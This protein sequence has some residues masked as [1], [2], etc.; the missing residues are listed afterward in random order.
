MPSV[1]HVSIVSVFADR[2]AESPGAVAVVCGDVSLTYGELDARAGR[3]ARV[4]VGRGVGVESRVGLLLERS[5]DVVVAMLAVVRAGGVYVP[6]HGSY[7]EERVRE[8][9]GR[10]GAVV[11]VTDRGLGEVGGVSAVGVDAGPVG[12]AVLPV[13]V[14]AGSLAYV[15]FTSGSTGVPKG[16][17][18]THGDVVALA[19]DSRW[20]ASGAHGRVLFHSPHSFDAAT[21]EVWVPLLNGGTADVAEAELSVS[22]VRAAVARGVSGLF[23]TKALFDVLAEEDPGCFAGLGEVWTG[24]EAA[25]GAAMARV[26]EACPETEL[27]HAYG[28]T[29]STTFAVCGPVGGVDTEGTT[30]PLGGPMDN[31]SAYVLDD[32]LRP[33]GVGVSGE[34]YLGGAGLARGYDGRAGLTAER[35]VAD[36]FGSGERLYRT[37]DV[38]RWRSDG[39]LDFLGR[40]DGQV[41]VRG[42][43]I[44]LGE[45][46]SVLSR[47]AA[48]GRVSVIVRED[49]PGA[50]RLVAYLV[51][52]SG[53]LDVPLVREHAAGLLPEYMVPS[54]FVV[55]DE[56][57]LT[58]NGKVD[59]R[60]L[61][62]PDAEVAADYVAP[63]TDVERLLCQVWAEVLGAERVGVHD[64]FF[65]RG[66][67]SI[68]GLK[69]V[70]RVQ[71]ALG[72]ELSTRTVFDHPTVSAMA[73]AVARAQTPGHVHAP[74]PATSIAPV[75]RDRE[76]PLSYGQERLW[77][78]DDF[79]PG[80]VEYNTGLALRLTGDLDLAALRAALD[81][82]TAR[83]E[84]LRTTFGGGVQTVHPTLTVPL[85]A[86]DLSTENDADRPHA[87]DKVLRTE[88]S[89]PFDLVAGPLFRVLTVRLGAEEHVLVL[90]MHHIVT[91]GWSMGVVTR[92]LGTLYAAA[93]RGEDADLEELSVQYPDFAVW[94]READDAL[95]QQLGY[96][97]Q[98]LDGLEPLELPTDRP[99]PAVRTSA[100]ALHTF[101]V[102]GELVRR[103]ARSGQ[104]RGASMFMV[105]TAV[106]QLLLS[107]YSGQRDVAVGTVVSGR[108]RADLE[109][110]VGFFVN[111]LVLRARIDQDRHSF[112]DLLDHVRTT[113][114]DA[115]AHQEVPFDRV[116]DALA[117]ERDPS[118]TPLVQA[119]I[120]LQNSVDMAGDFAGLT[121][122]REPV[123][124]ESSRFDLTL[125]FWESPSG[126]T[127]ELE[128][129]TDLFDVG[130]VERLCGHWLVL[131]ERVVAEPLVPLV[132]VGMLGAGELERLL[133]EWAGPGVGV[134]ERSV[135]EL[136]QAR[137]DAAPGA[138]AVLGEGGVS[139]T[140]GELGGRVDRLAGYLASLGVGV[141]SRVGVSLPRSV[142]LVVAVLAVLRAGGAYVPLDPEYP[143]DRL[144]FMKAD[145]GVRVVVDEAMVAGPLLGGAGA[146]VALPV[147]D[148]VSL[149]SAAYVIYTSGSTGRP[150]G[151]VVPHGAMAGL[152]RWAVSLG[153]ERFSR[154][155]F[156]TS[157]NFDVSV[158]ELFGTL[159]A[160]GTVEVVRDVLALTERDS[161]SGSLV[162]AVPSAFAGV[163]GQERDVSA[164]LVVL[165]GEAFPAGLL[166]Q[167]RQAMPGAV[168]ANI[169][170]PTEA[171]VYA[172]GWFS[173]TDPASDGP[174]VPIGRPVAG[175]ATYVLDGGLSP[176]PVGVWG[177]LYLGGGLARGYHGRSGLTSER[178]VA[179]PFRSG[180]RLYRTGD[181]VRWR[182]DG[183]LEYAGR[184]DDQVK[185]RGFRIELGEI[186]S[187]LTS[188]ASV[189]QSV[190]VARED[191]P[192][193]KRLAA[194]LVADGDVGLDVDAVREHVASALPEYMVPAAFVVLDALPLNANGK[195]DRRS[196][197]APEF[198]AAESA[199][200]APRT[201][202]ERIL[203]GVWAEVLGLSRVGIEDNFFD[204]GGDSIISLQ[205][206]SRARRA[207]LALSSRD[208][209][210]H[211][212]I[213]TL[214]TK[215]GQV[216]TG[217]ALLAE[218]GLVTGAVGTTPV[219]EWFFDTHPVA[220]EHF[221]MGAGFT[222]SPGTDLDA[223]RAAVGA[224]LSQHDALRS[225]FTRT[226]DGT[227]TGHITPAVD[228]DAV[229]TVHHS[230]TEWHS[231]VAAAHAGLDLECGPLFRVLVGVTGPEASI[232]V[233]LAAHHLVVDGVSWRILLE[234][235]ESAYERIVAG[236]QP[237][238][239]PKGTSVRQWATRLAEHTAAG[240]FDAQLP[241]WLATTDGVTTRLPVD[242]PGGDNTVQ[243]ERSVSVR[244]SAEETRALLQ[245]V[246]A[247][248]RTRPNDVLLSALVRAAG[249]WAGGSR[250]AVD[251]EA[252]GR[253]EIFADTDLTRTVGWFT[254]IHPVVLDV[255]GDEGVADWRGT[256]RA[257]KERLRAVPDQGVGYG[258]LRYL[259]SPEGDLSA[260]PSA[261]GLRAAP[262]PE[263]AFNYL[264]QFGGADD[265]S[266]W[267]RSLVLNPGGEHHPA[268]LRSHVLEVVGAVQDGVL[269]F[270]W[271]YSA[272]L[273]DRATVWSLAERFTAELRS[274][275][276][277]CAE[278]DS[279][280]CSPSDFPLVRLTQAEIDL[281]ADDGRDIEDIYPLT[282]LQSGMLFHSLNA[283]GSAA[284]LEQFTFVMDGVADLDALARAWQRVV[285]ASD[286]LRVS[287][288]WEGLS[289]PVQIVHRRAEIPV[290]RVD[291]TGRPEA[292]RPELLAVLVAEDR[293]A[294]GLDPGSAPLTRVTLA[295][296][297]G[298]RVQV[299]WS[300]HHMLLD[301]WSSAAVLSDVAAEYA[302]EC[303]SLVSEAGPRPADRPARGAFREHL[304]WLADCD[305][306][307]GRAFWRDRLAGFEEPSALPFDRA[308][309]S[310]HRARSTD[311]VTLRLPAATAHAVVDFARRSRVTVGTMVHGAWALTLSQYAGSSDVVFGSTVSGRP[312]DQPGAESTVGLFINTLPVRIDTTPAEPVARWLR[313]IGDE[314]AEARQ[315]EYVA[316]HEISTDVPSGAALFDSLVVVE[317]Y[318]VDPDAAARHGIVLSGLDAVEST[319][320]PLT[321]TARA[322]AGTGEQFV[323]TFG[324]DPELFDADTVR[325]LAE[326]CARAL[327]ELAEDGERIVGTLTLLGGD[328][329]ARVLGEWSG[330][331]D[332]EAIPIVRPASVT[333]AFRERVAASPDAA[334][335]KC[336][337]T[338]LS[339][340]QLGRRADR[341]A[342]ALLK[343]GVGAGSRVGLLLERSSEV[344]VAMLAVLKAGGAYVPLHA[345]HPAR[346]MREV[347]ERS[348]AELLLIDGTVRAPEGVAVLDMADVEA[349]AG[350]AAEAASAPASVSVPSQAP[351]YV[352][353]TSG[354]TG[355]PK[356]VVVTHGGVVA[357]AADRRFGSETHRQVLFHSP[358]SFDAATYEVWGP[359]LN[360]GCVVVAD[361]ELTAQAVRRAAAHGVTAVFVTTALFGALADEDPGCF[362]GLRE[363]WT[364]GEAASAPAMA[365]MRAHCPDTELMHVYGPTETTTFAL[366]GPVAA[367]DT[368]GGPVPLGGP[369]DST[370]AYVLD[371]A[372]RPVGVG[373][374]GELYLG[375]SGLARGY[376][377]RAA[378]TAERFVADP[379]AAGARLYR[380]GDIV[381]RRDDGRVEFLGRND[382]QV[383]IRGF[384]IELGEIEALL[385][386]GQDIAAVAVVA[387]EDRPGTKRLVAYL[388]PAGGAVLDITS[389]REQLTATLPAYMVPSAFVELEALPLTV[390]G[391]VDRRA[392][393]APGHGSDDEEPYVA[394]RPG[395]EEL[396][397]GIWGEVLGT[398]QVGA[399]DDFFALGG[400]SIA[401][402]KVVSRVRAALGS[403]LSPRALFDHPTVA[404]LAAAA[405][406]GEDESV[407]ADPAGI[408]IAPAPRDGRPLP[409]SYAQE[410][411][412]FLDEFTP[413]G[414]E[415]NVVTTLRLTGT[416]DLSALQAAVSGLVARHEALRTTFDSADG[417]GVQKVHPALDVTVR[418]A[419]AH[420]E[421]E[422]DGLLRAEAAEPFDLRTGPLLRVLLVPE[423]TPA[424]S[425]SS[426]YLLMLTLHHIT[427]DGWSMGVITRELSELYAAALRGGGAELPTLPVQYPDY[428]VWQRERLTGDALDTHL[429]Y[430]REHLRE[431][432]VLELPTDRPRPAVRSGRGALH[433]FRVPEELTA[434][435]TEAAGRR[436][437]TL[438]M[439]LTAVTQLL[440]ARYSGQD[441]LAVATAVSGRERTELE[442]LVG[443]FVNTLILR[444]RIE[445]TADFAAL[446]AQ[447]RETTLA[448]FAHQ[449]VPF[450][451]LVEELD[452]ERDPSRTPLV[453]AAVTL[454]NAPRETFALPGLRVEETLPPVETAQFD[455]NIEFEPAPGRGLFAVVSYG[456]DLFDAG[457]VGRMAGHW[458][459]LAGALVAGGSG[460]VLGEVSMLGVV[461]REWV[462]GAGR[463]VVRGLSGGSVVEGFA[464]RVAE[465]PG[466]V[467]V[468][469]GDVLLTY[470]ELEAR[471][472]R[473]ARVL[474]ECGVGV[475]SRVGLLLERSVDVVVAMLAVVR[476]GGVYV[477]LHG[478]YP[479][480]RVREVLGRSGAVVVVTDRGLGE[481]GGVS[482]V[483]V[484]AG[485]VGD[486]ALPVRVAAGSLAYV[487]FTSGSTGVPK[488]VAVTH[489]DV[490]ALAADSR[491]SSGAH[492]RVLFHSPHSFD[493]A[494]YE[495]WVP[496]LNGGT[497]DVAE[498]DL[499]VSVVRAAVARGV[500]GVFLTKALFD[501]LAEEDPACFAGLGEVWT[502]GE[503]ASGAAMARVLEACPEIELVHV[504]GPTE[505]TT[506]AVCGP[507]EAEDVSA[508]AVP[509]GGPMDNTSAY[510]LD[511]SLQPT[512]IGVPGELY[513]GGA[514]LARG[515]DGRAGLTAER[516]VADP[517][518]SGGRLYRTG[519]VVRWQSDG[520]LDFL[521]R[522]DGQVKV[523]GFRIELGEIESVL[524]R[525]PAV[526][527]VSVIVREDRPG[528]KRLVAYLVP[529]SGELDVPLVREHAA[530]LLPEYMVPSAFVVL[531]ALPLTTNGKVDQR[532]LPAPDLAMEGEYVAPR[533]EAERVLCEVWADVL[534]RERVGVHDNF[535]SLGGD[536]ISS[537]QVVSRARRA[538]LDLTSR[539]VFLRQNIADLAAS[540]VTIE[541]RN[542]V[543]APQE[544]VSG[545]V[546]PTPIREW[547]FAHHPAAPHHFAMS[548]AFEL[549]VGTDPA[550][551]RSAVAA[552]LAQ[553]D[554]LRSTF[555]RTE[556][557]AHTSGWAGCIAP[558]TDVDAVFTVHDL[559]SAADAEKAWR[560]QVL[561]AQSGMDLSSGPLFRV[562]VGD[563]GPERPGWLF[564]AAH[565]LL[566][567]G[568]SWRILLEDLTRA[569]AQAAAGR[570]VR[571]GEKSASVQQWSRRLAGHVAAGGFDDQVG[572]W[573][574]VTDAG[575]TELPV[576]L[577]GGGN[578]MAAQATVDV[579][580]DTEE[581]AALLHRV[582]D[583]YR[584][585][586]DDVLLAALARTLR[587]W[588]G[589]ERTA[590]AVEGH[591]RE[592]LFGDLDLTRTVGWFTSI[593]PVALALPDSDDQASALMSVKEQLRAVPD[594]GLGYGALRHLAADSASGRALADAAEP[595][596]SFNYHGRFEGSADTTG[597]LRATLPAFGQDHHPAEE[598]AHLIDVIGV[599]AGGRL[600]FTWTYSTELH[601][602]A[603]IERLAKDFASE[604]SGFVRHCAQPDA[605]GR[606]PSDFPLA[607]LDQGTVDA[608]VG[609]GQA[610]RESAVEDIYPLTPMQSGM[611]LHTLT[612]PGV[613]LDQVSFLLEGAGDPG[614]L[615][616][617]WQ[618]LVDATPALRTQ[619]VWDGV[620][621]PLQVVRRHAAVDIRQLDW[622]DANP[623]EQAVLL[624]EL[625]D[626]EHAAGIDLTVAP[627]MRLV[628]IRAREGAVRVVWTFHHVV[629]D[630]WSTTQ[631][632]ED[633]FAQYR[634]V[635]SGAGGAAPLATRPPFR[636]YVEWLGRQD[637][638]AAR[639]Y[640]RGALAGFRSPTPLPVDRRPAPGHRSHA[641]ER[642]RIELSTED[643]GALTEMAGRHRLTLNSVVQGAWA[644]LLSRYSGESDVCFGATVSGRPADLP[645]MESTV[646][647]FLNTLP[648]RTRIPE[649]ESLLD[650]LG[651]LQTEQA[652]ARSFE[653][654]ALREVR[655][656]A[657]L[658]RGTE[659]FESIVVFENYPGNEEAAAAHGLRVTDVHAVD[660]AGYPLDL[661]AYADRDKLA[662]VLAYDPALFHHDRVAHM[663]EHLAVLLRGMPG[664]AHRPPADLPLLSDRG[665]D[666]LLGGQG[667]GDG[668]GWSG[669]RI[670]YED[671]S[672][673]HELIAAQA[674]RTPDAE[675]VVFG[676]STLTYAELD[677]RA[678]RLAQHLVTRGVGPETVTAICLER[679]PDMVVALLG[680]LKAGGAY[681]PLDPAHPAER[682]AYVLTDSAARLVI[683]QRSLADRLPAGPAPLLPL[684]ERWDLI[685]RLPDR[686]PESGV[687]PRDLAYVIYT[688]G[689]T[690][691]PKG[692]M[693]EHRSISHGAASWNAAY[694]FTGRGE[695]E[696][697][698]VGVP[699]ASEPEAGGAASD[700]PVS[701]GPVRQ[702]N[703]ASMSFDVFVSDLVHSLCHGGALVIAPPEAIADPAQL[704]TLI[705]TAR[706]T[707]LDTVPALATALADEAARYGKGL[708]LLRVLA[709]GADL[710]RTDDCR[711][712]L[713]Q[714]AEGTTVLNTYGVTEA[715]VESSLYPAVRGTLPDTAG[716]PIGRPNPGI[717]MYL[718]D[719]AL[720]PVP[721][722]VTGDLYLGGPSVARGYLNRPELTAL[723]FV[724][725]PFGTDPAER[726]Y[727]TGDRARYLPGGDIEFAGRADEQLK[728]RG[729]RIEPGEIE[730]ALR[731]HPSV[732]RAVVAARQ[733]GGGAAR[734]VG[735][736]VV[737]DGHTFAPGELRAHLKRLLPGYMVPSVFMELAS[738]P[739]NANGKVDR[740]ALPAP[741]AAA[742]ADTAYIAPRT[743][744]EEV[745]ADIWQEVLGVERIGAEDDFFELGGNSI[746]IL[747]INSR[748]RAAFGVGFSVRAFYD[749][750]TVA[751]LAVAV[752]ERILQELEDSM[753]R[754]QP[755][756][757]EH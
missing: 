193:V 372:L 220:P 745:L 526:G 171:T 366:C 106:T 108:E 642:V 42:F 581:T 284:Y 24:G 716:V 26:L 278:P 185:V 676:A 486:A 252:H 551:L 520:R 397:A 399:H 75:P 456:T 522:N 270:T 261:P 461:E 447:V 632:F 474:V 274:L 260:S 735:Y 376:D 45:I 529:S 34:L 52:S 648:V 342:H 23:L 540:A 147:P 98:Q 623:D 225:T 244:L 608:L 332:H 706:V 71:K 451:R 134:G 319:N 400:D 552:L 196:L 264:G 390:N 232:R 463:G 327:E 68:T 717:R 423:E 426:S 339:Y 624:R 67:D 46:E 453:Q 62:A 281:I 59:R 388:V 237:D 684:D 85:R 448:A 282:P 1:Q 88:Q 271:S 413:G 746:Q 533:T 313:R 736:T 527:R 661:T 653:H 443:F 356:G 249:P 393:P 647:N 215:A 140:Y 238:L 30:V 489:G 569:Y 668:E 411:L 712:L 74:S 153:E 352:M 164:D 236:G 155:L 649:T 658:P 570:P 105:L 308:P 543:L 38:V 415:Y 705:R 53:E 168:V 459:G 509:L 444:S 76:L 530:G 729:F 132:R 283:P 616:T 419:E 731:Q 732:A 279:S 750:P 102:P 144:E 291:W 678:N 120:V 499:S 387:R 311:R 512:G 258:A 176:A 690:G 12:D 126:L 359:L 129:T 203:C 175:K 671:D 585:R 689:S 622:T 591:G 594:R 606:T 637:T 286:A 2:L 483:G 687:T 681:V 696:G 127:A 402:L 680:V 362:A 555:I 515:Y 741:D 379:F 407:A 165:A 338:T 245:S 81:G 119:L 373:V 686:T 602:P 191:R 316:L 29:E 528:A 113:A 521:G 357:L 350:T 6:L 161:W 579:T 39:R 675:A 718:L 427:T 202:A 751:G 655:D 222:L 722:G 607:R 326:S 549:A 634:A 504:Y 5:V 633:V 615:A 679:G 744:G 167:T 589:R 662:L 394:P 628:L 666:R 186:E 184:G 697:P 48:V 514:G 576:D 289:E 61:P 351:A 737:R 300:F 617:A 505:S 511:G 348:G 141:E 743:P 322:G 544:A 82:L 644:L 693:V 79:T 181:V 121:A 13:R 657:E 695:I 481:V 288:A 438:S 439:A 346:R 571:L 531:D 532:A 510:V 654:L 455:L 290:T 307:A 425:S 257:V 618:R 516:F 747:Q 517:F 417:R 224:L 674:R 664:G 446:L 21:Y 27:V 582:P 412:W 15:M 195:L 604:I 107:R 454:Q 11:V 218:S 340:R 754:D 708:P 598:R 631:I 377:G 10:S 111:T 742:Q 358:H 502:G 627:L 519:D 189:A 90:S 753:Q 347:L 588:T 214:A 431:L 434:A 251:I 501:V 488:G 371:G 534:G 353:F 464:A 77:F 660:T 518:G 205:V 243:S 683:T 639:E 537:L 95:T 503:A 333:D 713:E 495:V 700:K 154:T 299:L 578:T 160:G 477:P 382:G 416:L 473:L 178:F 212:T 590:V 651:R 355:T 492:E 276:E 343:R 266:G 597:P 629:L 7:P 344:V 610:V 130:T 263:L 216:D 341:L 620:P 500:S 538:G 565:H 254:S 663:A 449:D 69:V 345:A 128:F 41:K 133:M 173:D 378:L 206:V 701:D 136:V 305:Q 255:P 508:S 470:G 640:W 619:V 296:L 314:Q 143:A 334:A 227:W 605:G 89:T 329:R 65:A 28:P 757:E 187:V 592:E 118:R 391:K 315:Y 437:A 491:W 479:E 8:V 626:E 210:L 234:D 86:V 435:L 63:R 138:V 709:A 199:Y 667:D 472:G 554:A 16:V 466:A 40:N 398:E 231:V 169:Y 228:L 163:L 458:L 710:W 201:E 636:D 471:A 177:E 568:V 37:G 87:L 268:E 556:R 211:P 586:T 739:L 691:R 124:R 669:R 125:E 233:V 152:V 294:A 208:V 442:G 323:L 740:R 159:A 659:L 131:A 93:V 310:A 66:G 733:D 584:T 600:T 707:H 410:R 242:R 482:A 547:F 117:P 375:G 728:I 25:S 389:V 31:T 309:D 302:A 611:L 200:T 297:P 480:E 428:A 57:P 436:G 550:H 573:R 525:H 114:L 365:R 306:A 262:V 374:P 182:A 721:V 476:A 381:R 723:R 727:R 9:L 49:R 614:L 406:V 711:R 609:V 304:R 719:S 403:G 560:E 241:Y 574:T 756:Q 688:S 656:C 734:L 478:S 51:P 564:I 497:V 103:L 418:I 275:I 369:M 724:A 392:L 92:E 325:R 465:S 557:A 702:L 755:E 580:L 273:H 14:A 364:G 317:N 190:V 250:W 226:P 506:F 445:A 235:L 265:T 229:F 84:A 44:E 64:D 4:L 207:G 335:V 612:E 386:R 748:I 496:L 162:S 720:R 475:E 179:D 78:L 298:Q 548:M 17:A 422:R 546:G 43:R 405:G 677:S 363:V 703:V 558:A 613:Y 217:P 370:L 188:H 433:T 694:G 452:P 641:A 330:A 32:A 385:T 536:S 213:S 462:V 248:Y 539:D 469:C 643:A 498:A 101:E 142:D 441:D 575:A 599:V 673:L 221:N 468:V 35:F 20:S 384:R 601:H 395:A 269:A 484:D 337:D 301:G 652:E 116:V 292:E 22:V 219:R 665:R 192:G 414:A 646:G 100:G 541:P 149:S 421:T 545:P 714:A 96:W 401:A 361:E 135:V 324:Y 91:D 183:V 312:A 122:R 204:L 715:T 60:A 110:L 523:R 328:E 409:L 587:T 638:A 33:V 429:E 487:M 194:Y 293:A 563:R 280:G 494:T 561:A 583:V 148:S 485:P 562:L 115:F 139:L 404:R 535:F 109:G 672:C 567:D 577:P 692:V 70:T 83:H 47:H 645:G 18:V 331:R 432:P 80:G 55:L 650:W 73:E 380:T 572:Y 112:D 58:V 267:Y 467:A 368:S 625:M 104:R 507:V 595:R 738:L 3:L 349:D 198:V 137:I 698:G 223:L 230:G 396:L 123:P 360:G 56:L 247:V 566:V 354:S 150:K 320:Y 704:L 493:A 593:H 246:P 559:T 730:S 513:L 94:Q 630:G 460:R 272:N 197:P 303:A 36:P 54:A 524:S 596:I 256:I 670:P 383:K 72:C 318:P 336:G 240:G 239:G 146:R 553:H 367:G 408:G 321:L 259:P 170:G 685:A 99:R 158:F 542:V 440:L 635:A 621:E 450:S 172:T 209:F 174:M 151:V 156:S 725:D 157:L 285:D 145:S 603:T 97:R 166:E 253:E 180:G 699:G 430:W 752:E 424:S 726:L 682:L 295:T 19:A 50:K 277:H 749:S 490:V 287:I 457:T 420:G